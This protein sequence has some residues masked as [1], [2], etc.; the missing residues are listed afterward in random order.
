MTIEI[1]ACTD[2]SW[3]IVING[4]IRRNH[5]SL[6]EAIESVGGSRC[7]VVCGPYTLEITEYNPPA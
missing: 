7:A 6:K 4:E 5:S 2:N 3:D 1:V